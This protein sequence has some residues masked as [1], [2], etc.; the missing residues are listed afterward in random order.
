MNGTYFNR[1]CESPLAVTLWA[2]A[3]VRQEK[4]LIHA[5]LLADRWWWGFFYLEGGDLSG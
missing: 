2:G 3:A 5:P 1:V 4:T